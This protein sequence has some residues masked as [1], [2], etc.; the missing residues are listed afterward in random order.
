MADETNTTGTDPEEAFAVNVRSTRDRLD[1]SQA[2]LAE[3]VRLRGHPFH[4]TTIYKIETG[5]R[6]VNLSEAVAIAQVLDTPLNELVIDADPV[7]RQMQRWAS[8]SLRSQEEVARF[9]EQLP[10]WERTHQAASA[11]FFALNNLLRARDQNDSPAV[12]DALVTIRRHAGFHEGP[13]SEAPTTSA[14]ATLSGTEA[15]ELL[16]SVGA[17]REVVEQAWRDTLSDPEPARFDEMDDDEYERI[18]PPA[19][20]FFDK[21]LTRWAA[22]DAEA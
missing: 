17:P 8:Y 10:I 4:Q 21:V 22:P 2:D 20:A 11:V 5:A 1:M 7:K 9:R 19:Q 13:L 16:L 14:F 12:L 15:R 18:G 6:R 3:A